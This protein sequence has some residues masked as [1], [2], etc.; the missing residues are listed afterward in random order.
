MVSVVVMKKKE[1]GKDTPDIY[2]SLAYTHSRHTG[3]FFS[4]DPGL[5]SPGPPSSK[6]T[7]KNALSKT[8][9]DRYRY[10]RIRLGSHI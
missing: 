4:L 9:R 1:D 7:K 8:N 6:Q 2:I 10:H 3:V 5:G